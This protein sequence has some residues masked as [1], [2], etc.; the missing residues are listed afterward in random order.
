M[1]RLVIIGG[2]AAG[3]SAAA[4]ARRTSEDIEIVMVEAG[5]YVIFA[6]CG[7]PYYLGGEIADR[8]DLFVSNAE[9]FIN[10]FNVDVRLNT[11]AESINIEKKSVLL[12]SLDGGKE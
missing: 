11:T 2:V 9:T 4:K 1:K 10:R 6:N 8:N 12:S 7:L 5:P 3:A